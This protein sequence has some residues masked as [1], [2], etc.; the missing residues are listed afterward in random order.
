MDLTRPIRDQKQ[1][2]EDLLSSKTLI[3]RE[4]DSM[5]K[6][7]IESNLIKVVS[8]IR[9]SGKSVLIYTFLKDKKF[10]YMNFDDDRLASIKT[11][12]I[13]PAFYEVYGKDLK[14]IFLDEI[15][16]LENWELF[17]NRIHR[18]GF[19][20]LIT[21]SNSK[22]LSKELA[23][24]L[25]GRHFQIELMPFS[26]REYLVSSGFSSDINTTKGIS[27][28]K[29]ELRNYLDNGGF[30]EI[31]A[32]KENP[33]TYLMELY[34]KIIDRDIIQRHKISYK[35]TFKEMAFTLFSNPGTKITYNRLKNQFNLKSEHT[36]KNYLSH[37]EESYLIFILSRF[38]SKPVEVEKS[39]KKIY[40]VDTGFIKNVSFRT[41]DDYG[42]IY[43]N[44]VA[45]ELLRRKFL[46]QNTDIYYFK[47]S[48]NEEVDFV[49]KE[50]LKI[51]QLIQVCYDIS[52]PDTKKRE[53]RA[54]INAS[55]ELKCNNLLI[56]TDD[57]EGEEEAVWFGTKRKIKYIPLWKWLLERE[58]PI[59]RISKT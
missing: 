54:L 25:T 52:R 7:L 18:T 56:I 45:I 11:E 9:R 53:V 38:S 49:L 10:A 34:R 36:A 39:E 13:L 5:L 58:R 17:V 32:E 21:G 51:K 23:T 46:N 6:S 55:K 19:N 4:A 28:L 16:N 12:D 8:G 29:K 2:L 44:I 48:Q 20:L 27:L 31:V 59:I 15:Q 47:T 57:K 50:G 40:L 26:F 22:L 43:E 35:K 33:K 3:K 41:T 24:H 37:L 42:S 30:P 1:E 14:F